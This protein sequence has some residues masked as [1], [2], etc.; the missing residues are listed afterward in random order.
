MVQYMKI[1]YGQPF[2]IPRRL[3]DRFKEVVGIRGVR[4]VR[5]KGFVVSDKAALDAVNRILVKMGLILVPTINCFICGK[6]VGCEECEYRDVCKRAVV[7]CL[8][9][10]CMN[11]EDFVK[12]YSDVQHSLFEDAFR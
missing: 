11:A 4:Y 10:E 8:C 2:K 6:D 1:Y 3:G 5:Q 12:K 7:T 9:A